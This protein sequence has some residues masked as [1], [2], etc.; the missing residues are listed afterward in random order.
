MDALETIFTRRSIRRFKKEPVSEEVIE[1]LLRAGM[2]APSA[3]NTQ[4]WQFIVLNER[5]LLHAIADFHP[6]A[7]MLNEAPSAIAICGDK[8]DEPHEGYLAVN[9]AAATQNILL[10][11]HALGLGAV[12]IGIYPRENRIQ[13]LS[14]L[15]HL[16]DFILPISLVAFGH[17]AEQKSPA[18]R[19]DV[20]KV[21]YNTWGG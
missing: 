11:A 9:C 6:F 20:S 10:A 14:A 16:P 1:Q 19:F 17:P 13:K 15:L 3:R 21:H 2:Q 8:R 4:A 18:D 5:S 7:S 12:W